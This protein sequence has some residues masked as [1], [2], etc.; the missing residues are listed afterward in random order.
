[1][2]K[3]LSYS[4]LCANLPVVHRSLWDK[5]SHPVST[6]PPIREGAHH[7]SCTINTSTSALPSILPIPMSHYTSLHLPL[8]QFTDPSTTPQ[9]ASA[10]PIG[11]W[12]YRVS[13]RWVRENERDISTTAQTMMVNLATEN[14]KVNHTHVPTA[15]DPVPLSIQLAAT[16]YH[17]KRISLDPE[18]P[19][20][21]EGDWVEHWHY[22]QHYPSAGTHHQTEKEW[23]QIL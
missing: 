5:C 14:T 13:Y 4:L 21:Q 2:L 19:E 6:I 12:G 7:Y 8:G 16:D 23:S 11:W 9:G 17:A 10:V 18:A 15:A 3:V 1:M 20:A 22:P